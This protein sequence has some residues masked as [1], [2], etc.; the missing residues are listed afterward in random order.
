MQHILFQAVCLKIQQVRNH[1]N[2]LFFK[3]LD[4]ENKRDTIDQFITV[5]E[6]GVKTNNCQWLILTGT[7]V[8]L[9]LLASATGSSALFSGLDIIPVCNSLSNRELISSGAELAAAKECETSN[10][11]TIFLRVVLA[12]N[13]RYVLSL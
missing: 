9:T 4:I 7:G 10:Y 5:K 6:S 2:L 12:D 13:I 3:L 11:S 8:L 1:I